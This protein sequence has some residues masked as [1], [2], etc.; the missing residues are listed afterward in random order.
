MKPFNVAEGLTLPL[1]SLFVF[2]VVRELHAPRLDDAVRK[3]L[4]KGW[5]ESR[6]SITVI[7]GELNEAHPW[8]Q[9]II[10][11]LETQG[12]A[13]EIIAAT[14]IGMLGKYLVLDGAHRVSAMRKIIAT[15]ELY[16]EWL[17]KM[18]ERPITQ[19]PCI[20]KTV[21]LPLLLGIQYG[22]CIN[23]QDEDTFEQGVE[24]TLCQLTKVHV[25]E[26]QTAAALLSGSSVGAKLIDRPS[27]FAAKP[28][29]G[30]QKTHIQWLVYSRL[31]RELPA[32]P[33]STCAIFCRS[34]LEVMNMV[35]TRAYL[36]TRWPDTPFPESPFSPLTWE[37]LLR[38]WLASDSQKTQARVAALIWKAF[39]ECHGKNFGRSFTEKAEKDW[40]EAAETLQPDVAGCPYEDWAAV[41]ACMVAVEDVRRRELPIAP[42]LA[43]EWP[44]K[45]AQMAVSVLLRDR[46]TAANVHA[47]LQALCPDITIEAK[48][49]GQCTSAEIAAQDKIAVDAANKVVLE[50][51]MVDAAKK[52]AEAARKHAEKVEAAEKDA[53][54]AVK[55]KKDA[56]DAVKATKDAA[57]AEKVKAK[58]DRAALDAKFATVVAQV[59]EL[60]EKNKGAPGRKSLRMA[61]G[62]RGTEEAPESE[63]KEEGDD[64]DDEPAA[65]G[66]GGVTGGGPR[67]RPERTLSESPLTPRASPLRQR[68]TKSSSRNGAQPLKKRP[69]KVEKRERSSLRRNLWS[70]LLPLVRNAT[71]LAWRSQL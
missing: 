59:E 39:I 63:N 19:V 14:K 9:H 13:P 49:V 45:L 1:D 47:W 22:Q 50:A 56:A 66:G 28:K 34:I 10:N 8:W 64:D 52:D 26:S 58:K 18:D 54:D 70:A 6:Q 17:R 24:E 40:V 29:S 36:C 65:G 48:I 5:D 53:A 44:A 30:S 3:L 60:E 32:D 31:Q 61:K 55:A 2:P 35:A 12:A 7:A 16:S 25:V 11:L 15:L 37:R 46:L 38:V 71:N 57:D 23:D 68:T 27:F 43:L 67:S 21:R 4:N 51:M 62:N 41:Q 69:S 20:V 42:R 33:F